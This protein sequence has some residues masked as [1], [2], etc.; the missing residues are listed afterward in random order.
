MFSHNAIFQKPIPLEGFPCEN[1]SE[2]YIKEI[3]EDIKL[4]KEKVNLVCLVAV[5]SAI[6]TFGM[7]A[8]AYIFFL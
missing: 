5:V 8:I 2:K 3:D 7:C 1:K 4:Y 6:A